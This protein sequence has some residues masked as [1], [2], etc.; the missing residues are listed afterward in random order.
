MTSG[1]PG[2]NV[3]GMAVTSGDWPGPLLPVRAAYAALDDAGLRPSDIG[4][5]IHVGGDESAAV[6]AAVRDGLGASTCRLTYDVGGGPAGFVSALAVGASLLAEGRGVLI[7]ETDDD[8]AASLV[9][10]GA[11]S[12]AEYS[13]E[14]FVVRASSPVRALLSSRDGGH[15]D[16]LLVAPGSDGASVRCL[17]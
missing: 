4:A 7:T 17:M 5:V 15:A 8:G 9:L 12:S 14:P 2:L 10:T 11:A 13:A 3:A 1:R 16:V 6:A